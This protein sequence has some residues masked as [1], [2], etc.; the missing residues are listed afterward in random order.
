M[1]LGSFL[2]SETIKE[3]QPA[4]DAVRK[5]ERKRASAGIKTVI[6]YNYTTQNPFIASCLSI[7]STADQELIW[8]LAWRWEISP[9]TVIGG[10]RYSLY[11]A[12]ITTIFAILNGTYY[13]LALQ[14]KALPITFTVQSLLG[15]YPFWIYHHHI[16]HI[17]YSIHSTWLLKLEPSRYFICQHE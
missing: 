14:S 3:F 2:A 15:I 10:H 13:P 11:G 12:V 8:V 16:F 7:S 5:E 17:I 1:E 9:F 4:A 6:I